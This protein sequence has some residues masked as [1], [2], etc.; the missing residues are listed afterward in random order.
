MRGDLELLAKRD[1]LSV[2]V[3]LLLDLDLFGGQD[4]S[5]TRHSS[6]D[7]GEEGIRL[8]DPESEMVTGSEGR[9][10]RPLGT[11]SINLTMSIPS[12]TLP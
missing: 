12:R 3:N 6:S 8:T 11:P 10:P 9:S 4:D 1:H 5:V 2:L 7:R